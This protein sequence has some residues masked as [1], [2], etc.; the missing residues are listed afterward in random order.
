MRK[1]LFFVGIHDKP[2]MTPLNSSSFSGSRVDSIIDEVKLD[3]KCIKTNFFDMD[4]VPSGFCKKAALQDW[5]NRNLIT[6]K[7][8]VVVLGNLVGDCFKE[9]FPSRVA[10]VV[11]KHPSPRALSSDKL[12]EWKDDAVR[13]IKQFK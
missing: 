2:G 9:F 5:M 11:I 12:K 8:R 1:R 3:Y 7:D 13:L 10:F 4:S 6:Y